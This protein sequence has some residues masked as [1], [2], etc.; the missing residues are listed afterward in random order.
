MLTAIQACNIA[1]EKDNHKYYKVYKHCVKRIMREITWR[2][3]RG[4]TKY[5]YKVKATDQIF[6]VLSQIG[7]ELTKLKYTTAVEYNTAE[8]KYLLTI[9]WDEI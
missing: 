6:R 2:A 3:P 7:R 5:I 8:N 9:C 4:K 1:K